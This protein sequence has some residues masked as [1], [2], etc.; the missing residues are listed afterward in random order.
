MYIPRPKSFLKLILL[1]FSFVALPLLVAL[2][3][4]ALYMD[5]MANQSQH[6]VYQAARATKSSRILVEQVTVMERAARQYLVLGDQA[7][8]RA[9]KESHEKLQITIGTLLNLSLEQALREKL[10]VLSETEHEILNILSKNPHNI[11]KSKN[12][13]G[14]FEQLASISREVLTG[15]QSIIDREVQ[16]MYDIAS[17]AQALFFWFGLTL[18]PAVIV[19]VVGFTIM[20]ARP[21][22]QITAVPGV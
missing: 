1:G 16:V 6:A 17:S 22:R 18:I 2:G 13:V 14:K 10:I 5:R 21:I 4:A 15:S 12:A 20:I 11:A 7:L 8:L 9:Y 3:F 19:I